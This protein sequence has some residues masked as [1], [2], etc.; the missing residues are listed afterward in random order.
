LPQATTRLKTGETVHLEVE[1]AAKTPGSKSLGPTVFLEEQ[2]R[3][4]EDGAWI[5]IA[6]TGID[7][8]VLGD[9]VQEV[10]LP[11]DTPM[12][13]V[14]FAVRP[15]AGTTVPGVARLRVAIYQQNNLIQCFLVAALL[16]S[17][18]VK[19][20]AVSLGKVLNT[21]AEQ[22]RRLGEVGY[23]PRLEYAT[24]PSVDPVT[25]RRRGLTIIANE[26]AGEKVVTF[27]G[28]DLFIVKTDP[29]LPTR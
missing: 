13:R 4:S 3:W 20:P 23:L 6:V 2:V 11:R 21:S 1:I 14:T 5:E 25:A 18:K 27:K 12:D 17:S 26:S 28:D 9:P 15:R 19:D 29:L 22:I 7:F 10:W 16:K 8:D 24:T